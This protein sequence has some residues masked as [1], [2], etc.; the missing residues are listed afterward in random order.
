VL[1][2]PPGRAMHS[3]NLGH[4]TRGAERRLGQDHIQ[5]LRGTL[6]AEAV[7]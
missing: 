5:C 2:A 1:L 6:S 3:A 4:A 7:L